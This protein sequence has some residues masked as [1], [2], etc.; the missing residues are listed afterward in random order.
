MSSQRRRKAQS[1]AVYT[2]RRILVAGAA[3]VVPATIAR[4]T[5]FGKSTIAPTTSSPNA[6]PPETSAAINAILPSGAASFQTATTIAA[7][8]TAA[9]PIIARL[10]H[11]LSFGMNDG[12]V[13][14]LQTQLKALGFDPGEPDGVFGEATIRAVW[15]FEKLVL[16]T[17]RQETTGI[18][19]PA[20]WDV[21][22]AGIE[23][24]PLRAGE[25]GTHVEVYL[26]EQVA[27]LF[28]GDRAA[29]IT[30]VSTGEGVEWCDEVLIDNEDGTQTTKGICG[31]SITPGG[32]FHFERKVDG[33]R[34]AAL[35]RLYNPV[36]FNYGLAIHGSSNVP[37][38]P[39]SHGCVRIPMHIAEYFPDR[40]SIGD[41]I[42]IFDGR[43]Q[44]EV[45]G[46][47][48]PI[49]DWADPNSTT[50]TSSSTTSPST[51]SGAPAT[52]TS[53]AS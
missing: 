49:F 16:G 47:Q 21:M 23:V 25:H 17:R 3:L 8:T 12:K 53:T 29:L 41:T 39:A 42:Y 44:P 33:W 20:T 19:T 10:D 38:R 1:A 31:R 30:H 28:D 15:A 37:D 52:T 35:G 50:T 5:L 2:R 7:S 48:P 4:R 32:V 46:A 22:A 6:S 18:V 51:T 26:P 14:M 24:R 40:V 13:A 45:Y 36:Y 43:K 11:D 9:A 27:V 34:N